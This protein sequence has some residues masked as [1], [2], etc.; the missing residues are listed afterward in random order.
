MELCLGTDDN[1]AYGS[2]LAGRPTL[3]PLWVS[4]ADHPIRKKQTKPSSENQ[5]KPRVQRHWPSWGTSTTPIPAGGT[6]PRN[7]LKCIND[8]FLTRM[9][10][11]PIRGDTAGLHAC[12]KE[13]LFGDV[14]VGRSHGCWLRD[15]EAQHREGRN[16]A[17]GK[18]TG[19]ANTGLTRDLLGKN[20][21]YMALERSPGELVDFQGSLP[22]SSRL[23]QPDE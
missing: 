20:P 1:P 21:W 12:E 4:A 2:G 5:R 11:E 7:F 8:N 6:R 15:G 3:A 10:E 17:E 16:K 13:E 9:S 18:I 22:P 23:I 14:K 19:R